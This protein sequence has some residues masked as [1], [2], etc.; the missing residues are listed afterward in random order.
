MPIY[1][2]FGPTHGQ[3]LGTVTL[4]GYSG[5]LEILQLDWDGISREA[6]EVTSMLVQPTTGSGFGNRRFIQSAYVDPGTLKLQLLHDPTN[7]IPIT[8]PSK[9]G[10]VTV[11]V[12]LGPANSKQET[13]DAYGFVTKWALNGPLDGKAV[14]STLEIKLTDAVDASFSA[15]GAVGWTAAS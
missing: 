7:L 9:I 1:G 14:T 13:F 10:P 3:T 4:Q 5:L 15:D 2:G 6:I 12:T 8:D 11:T